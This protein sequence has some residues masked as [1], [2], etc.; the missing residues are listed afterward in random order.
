M[1]ARYHRFF[2]PPEWI[3]G[4]HVRLEGPV[5]HQIA[6]VL[7]MSRGDRV[8][9][10]DN[11]GTEWLAE[12]ESLRT[13]RIEG[14]ILSRATGRGEPRVQVTLYQSVLK[15]DRMEW[16][17][18]KGTELG[19]AAF[20]PVVSRRSVSR[21]SREGPALTRWRRIV[22]EAAEQSGRSLLPTVHPVMQFAEALQEL[23]Q[24]PALIPY[25]EERER[26]M[27]EALQAVSLKGGQLSIFIGP[28]GGWDPDEVA[29]AQ[30]YGVLP[31]S[32]GQRILRAE[33]AAIAAI[34]VAM[35]FSG[36][37]GQ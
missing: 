28:E 26:L 4:L 8:I 7:R 31:A 29:L 20:V 25:E 27:G 21:P 30:S 24:G 9:I 2:V 34:T 36:E 1:D 6:R 32:L 12:L 18:Q 19:A 14:R 3:N 10:L 15:S 5:A 13:D 22:T 17:L 33:T 23:P 37:L 35:Y 16:V 11:S